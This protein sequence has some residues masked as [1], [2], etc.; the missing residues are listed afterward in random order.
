MGNGPS[1]ERPDGEDPPFYSDWVDEMMVCDA[2]QVGQ[3]ERE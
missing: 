3:P 1:A 2:G